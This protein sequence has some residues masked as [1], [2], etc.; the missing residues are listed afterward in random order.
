M[1][2]T[3]IVLAFVISVI[4][5]FVVKYLLRG[6]AWLSCLLPL[7]LFGYFLT[8]ITVISSGDSL[9]E[10]LSWYASLGINLDFK[11][12]GLSLI[13]S[14]MIT[15]VGSLIF[16]YADGYLGQHKYLSRFYFLLS[17]FMSA[18]LGLVLADNLL[19]LFVFWEITTISSYLLVGFNHE[20]DSSRKSAL[21]ALL[22]TGIGGLA[23]LAGFLILGLELGTFSISE[24][25][26]LDL[27]LD[28]QLM[29]VAVALILLGCFTKSGQFPFHFWLPNAMAAPTPVSAYL[30]SA[31]MVKAGIY[32]MYRFNMS[33][34]ESPIWSPALLIAGGVTMLFSAFTGLWYKDLKKILAYSTLSVLGMLT[35]LAGLGTSLSVTAGLALLLA[36]A[37]YKATLFMLAGCIDHETGTRDI[38]LLSGLRK[39][40]PVSFVVAVLVGLSQAGVI[41]FFGFVAKEYLIKSVLYSDYPILFTSL[42][43]VTGALIA[44]LA[45]FVALKPFFGED[46]SLSYPKKEVHEA[47]KTM[48]IGPIIL[49]FLSFFIGCFPFILDD[50]LISQATKSMAFETSHSLNLWEGFNLAFTLSLLS[51][52]IATVTYVFRNKVWGLVD[53]FSVKSSLR[54]DLSFAKGLV[55]FSQFCKWQTRVIQNGSLKSYMMLSISGFLILICFMFF[56]TENIRYEIDVS[57]LKLPQVLLFITLVLASLLTAFSKSLMASL[58]SMGFLGFGMAVIYTIYGAPDLAITQVMVESLTAVMFM[59]VIYKLPSLKVYNSAGRKTFDFFFSLCCGVMVTL[60]VLKA[61]SLQLSNS[62]SQKM[63]D[64]SYIEAK[65]RNVVNVILVDFRALDTLGEITVLATAAIGAAILLRKNKKE[66]ES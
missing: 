43:V 54:F 25:M 64:L 45:C 55:A 66:K 50:H 57:E 41:P 15:G 17:V 35:F 22:I 8:K 36:H 62:V 13:F 34:L 46:T 9:S 33:F 19:L 42:V 2:I 40:M 61:Q 28:S 51:L 31:T 14:L 60:L 16:I 58:I 23:M 49:A 26:A 24:I 65:G 27:A 38:S 37:M 29:L 30:H 11:L 3:V 7:G 32:L 47:P 44:L 53:S 21:Q 18:M 4:M 63:A 56:R 52:T 5:P 10:S 39:Y 20:N 6:R 48:L 59:A 1:L 12:D